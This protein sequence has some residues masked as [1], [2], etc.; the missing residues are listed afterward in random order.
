MFV[1][2]PVGVYEPVNSKMISGASLR[3]FVFS[4]DVGPVNFVNPLPVPPFTLVIIAVLLVTPEDE[5]RITP[6]VVK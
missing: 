4:D 6:A 2:V 1:Q 5:V 3:V